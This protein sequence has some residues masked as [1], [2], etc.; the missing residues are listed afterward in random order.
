M[1]E[2]NFKDFY[3]LIVIG[4]TGA[5]KSQFCNFVQRDT[6][7]TKNK[8][9]NSL[10][11][12]TQDPKSNIFE[13]K[14]TKYEFIDTAGNS[15]SS[16]NDEI[17]LKKLVEYLKEKKEI[18]YIALLLKYGERL[19]KETR[20]YIHLLGKIFTYWEFYTHLCVFFTKSPPIPPQPKE[21]DPEYKKKNKKYEKAKK[22]Q[23]FYIKE[24]NDILR[25]AFKVEPNQTLPDIKVY[26]ID[27]QY[28]ED[29]EEYDERYQ[30]AVDIMIMQMKLDVFKF[31]SLN[32]SQLDYSGIRAENKIRQR[33]S[34]IE[35][36]DKLIQKKI[37]SENDREKKINQLKEDIQKAKNKN[38]NNEEIQEKEK[39]LENLIKEL[40]DEKKKN[41]E[42]LEKLRNF[43]KNCN[44]IQKIIDNEAKEKGINVSYLDNLI[45]NSCKV[46]KYLGIS[47]GI[48]FLLGLGGLALST[49]CPAAAPI[50]ATFCFT[51]AGGLTL[52][53]AGAGAVA[54]GAKLKKDSQNP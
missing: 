45:D 42:K 36:L 23:Q 27:T 28:D 32:T 30:N 20:A 37:K 38:I 17:N 53:S 50:V 29:E 16:D 44:E 49:A 41:N 31:H 40:E 3:R 48:S 54:L 52:G 51:G 25:E 47:G 11:S 22:E 33:S 13:R 7:N 12:C 14:K 15:D 24:I 21:K 1:T 6:T 8:V 46:A 5:G 4:P 34:T 39:E 19:T 43:E 10:N 9:S 18:D 35:N 26:F 2:E